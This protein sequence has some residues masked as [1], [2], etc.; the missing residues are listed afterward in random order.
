MPPKKATTIVSILTSI[1]TNQWN[2][3]LI[4]EARN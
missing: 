4:R 2:E 1:D 3:A